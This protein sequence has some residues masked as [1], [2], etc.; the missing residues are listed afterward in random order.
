MVEHAQ[1]HPHTCEGQYIWLNTSHCTAR[2][3][4]WC[5]CDNTKHKYLRHHLH[6]HLVRWC[7]GHLQWAKH[8][9]GQIN[10]AT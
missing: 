7:L 8:A 5:I 4:W 2:K 6:N 3:Q 1:L 9:W 10:T